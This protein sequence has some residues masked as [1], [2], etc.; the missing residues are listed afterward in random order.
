MEDIKIEKI[1]EKIKELEWDDDKIPE[2]MD[3]FF[4]NPE[5]AI[6][7][8]KCTEEHL[9]SLWETLECEENLE[10]DDEDG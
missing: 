4:N 5:E 6:D 8:T 2:V 7:I 1:C 3:G 10:E 9:E